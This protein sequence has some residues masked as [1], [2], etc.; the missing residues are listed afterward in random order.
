VQGSVNKMLRDLWAFM[1][2]IVKRREGLMS[3][4]RA[5]LGP[6]LSVLAYLVPKIVNA[7]GGHILQPPQDGYVR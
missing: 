3:K 7:T 1:S 5:L 4:L 6:V 2:A